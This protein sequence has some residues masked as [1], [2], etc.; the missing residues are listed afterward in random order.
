MGAYPYKPPESKW[1]EIADIFTRMDEELA[2]IIRQ[3]DIVIAYLSIATGVPVEYVKKAIQEVVSG[4]STTITESVKTIVSPKI[5]VPVSLTENIS[6][7]APRVTVQTESGPVSLQLVATLDAPLKMLPPE[8]RD[9]F[10]QYDTPYT[11]SDTTVLA[12][13]M[14]WDTDIWINYQPTT[15]R[16]SF[17]VTSGTLLVLRPS[18]DQRTI[19]MRAISSSGSV[20]I[21]EFEKGA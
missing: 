14:P 15:G 16:T 1:Y 6:V 9:V 7:Q 4:K 20:Y 8:K 5:T 17:P 18:S 19:Y 21:M 13:V 3:L 11:F 2:L 10:P 12:W